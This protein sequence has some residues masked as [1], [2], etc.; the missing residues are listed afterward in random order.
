MYVVS[1]SPC[2]QHLLSIDVLTTDV[3]VKLLTR[4]ENSSHEVGDLMAWL[5]ENVSKH[6]AKC[7]DEN[8]YVK[9]V[10]CLIK[11]TSEVEVELYVLFSV[12]T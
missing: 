4:S 2:L 10:I 5:M 11:S 6:L 8:Y 9:Y 7:D 1:A 3:A 12:D